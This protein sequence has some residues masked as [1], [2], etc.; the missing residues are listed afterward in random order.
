M[1]RSH[2]VGRGHQDKSGRTVGSGCNPRR[3]FKAH[4]LISVQAAVGRSTQVAKPSFADA[5][6]LNSASKSHVSMAQRLSLQRHA[7]GR[8]DDPSSPPPVRTYMRTHVISLSLRAHTAN[9]SASRLAISF[10][11]C[12]VLRGKMRLLGWPVTMTC[13]LGFTLIRHPSFLWYVSIPGF[14]FR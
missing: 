13:H 8:T 14:V 9:N 5:R 12:I 6:H 3:A 1:S 4:L 7:D 2:R 11:Y 10:S